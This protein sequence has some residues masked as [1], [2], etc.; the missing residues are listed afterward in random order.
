MITVII[1]IL[2]TAY[3]ASINW[4]NFTLGLSLM[5]ASLTFRII[6]ELMTLYRK[7]NQLV[8]LDNRSFQK[9]L[10]QYYRLRLRINY[11]ITPLCFVIYIFGFTKLLPYFKQEFSANFYTYLSISGFAS[12]FVVVIIIFNSVLKERRFLN[13]LNKKA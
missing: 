9:Y 13:D 1:L 12:L 3:Y 2:F 7:D 4:N 5:I 10:K 11:I 8:S 6:L